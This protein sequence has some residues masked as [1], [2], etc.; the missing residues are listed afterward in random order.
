MKICILTAGKGSRIGPICKD[1]NKALLPI[2]H[3]PIISKI[4]EKFNADDTFVIG[5][6][7][8]KEQIKSYLKIAHPDK[9]FIFVN[10]KNHDGPGS[11]PGLSLLNCKKFLNES[12]VFVPCDCNFLNK[13]KNSS[14]KNWIGVSKVPLNETDQ[15]C[16]VMIN[17][18]KVTQIKDKEKCSN[19]YY[20]FTGLT[21]IR[22]YELFWN[23]LK[24]E[25]IIQNE[26]QI[27][28]G[29][30]NMVNESSLYVKKIKWQDMGTLKQFQHIQDN[31]ELKNIAKNNEFLY[32]INNKVIKFFSNEKI[33]DNKIS[34]SK[35]KPMF[36]P[37]VKKINKNFYFYPFWD[38]DIF[39][40]SGN[41]DAFKTLLNLLNEKFWSRVNI[42]KNTMQNIC[43]EFYHE[44]T[45]SRI[46]LFLELNP[47]YLYPKTVNDQK[48]L[49]LKKILGK[50]PWS[51]LYDGI[52]SFIHGDLNF[53][54]I[55]YHS[56]NK[57]FMFIDWRQ[58]FVGHVEY[59]DLYYDLAKLYAGILMN[60]N[61][62][63]TGHYNFNQN[64]NS[65]HIS[66][67]KWKQGKIYRKIFDEF[68]IAN[69]FNLKKIHILAGL[70]F[71][72]MAP[73]HPEPINKLLIAFGAVTISDGLIKYVS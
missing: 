66:L 23:G 15:Y 64:G 67:K 2:G 16:N 44:K 71:L 49:P 55:L 52:P 46:K 51:I 39:Y 32:I 26:R 11:G 6:G 14:E 57:K 4:I 65:A 8:K 20:T 27:S 5:L 63:I 43:K 59:G 35:L 29:L 10:I 31:S 60:F 54:N 30:Q 41:T 36:F 19:R 9:K 48:I 47:N 21:H 13:F 18:C 1:I 72:N 69:G 62:I 50:I 61:N 25:V 24:K 17:N 68:A 12:F 40:D 70:T 53:S 37:K 3:T 45:I 56:K 42:K 58:D 38:G 7:Y 28:N 22:D 34:K 33:I 73:L